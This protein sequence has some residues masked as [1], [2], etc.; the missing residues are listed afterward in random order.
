M[1]IQHMALVVTCGQKNK[2][3]LM[4]RLFK[5]RT[6]MQFGWCHRQVQIYASSAV[7]HTAPCGNAGFTGMSNAGF[8]GM[9][10]AERVVS[11]DTTRQCSYE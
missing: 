5:L 6:L 9:S 7:R 4:Q 3:K 2:E 11:S 10:T 8:I 1:E